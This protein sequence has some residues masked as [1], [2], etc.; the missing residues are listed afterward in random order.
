LGSDLVLGVVIYLR[1]VLLWSI[2]WGS[3]CEELARAG[4]CN[5]SPLPLF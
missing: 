4:W 5:F 2:G 3:P 1:E